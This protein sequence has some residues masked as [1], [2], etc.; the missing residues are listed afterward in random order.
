MIDIKLV[1]GVAKKG[2]KDSIRKMFE[3][4]FDFDSDFIG[5]SEFEYSWKEAK[6]YECSCDYLVDEIL[7]DEKYPTIEDKAKKFINEYMEHEGGDYYYGCEYNIIDNGDEVIVSVA[8]V[9]E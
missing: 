2:D 5:C 8:F 7:N 6:R 1:A 3:T 4:L 9:S